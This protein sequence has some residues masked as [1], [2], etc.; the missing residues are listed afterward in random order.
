MMVVKSLNQSTKRITV[1]IRRSFSSKTGKEGEAKKS[2]FNDVHF[3]ANAGA[4]AGWGMSGAAIYDAMQSGPEI[5]S[6]NM[7]GVMLIYS[8]LFS[9]WAW[10]VSPR[11][12]ALS[13]CHAT[14][15][16]AQANQMRRA[17]EYKI[18]KGETEEV[19]EIGK[20]GAM[21]AAVGAGCVLFGP[22][23]QTAIASAN[24]GPIST[25]SAAAAGPFTV[26][27]WAPMS[28]W[29][30]SGASF[31]DMDRPTDKISLPQYCAL[32]ATGFFFTRYALLVVPINYTLCS[33]NVALFGSSSYHLG[34]KIKADYID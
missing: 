21:V 27:F 2:F 8:S 33:V 30:I 13:A 34:R 4:A 25:V 5:I 16:V 6:L 20:K 9:R 14:N 29:L 32:T 22:M 19:K 26:H 12:V 24:L 31:L 1:S 17:L 7:T 23:A 3:W 10:I 11:N 28:K 18:S 15:I